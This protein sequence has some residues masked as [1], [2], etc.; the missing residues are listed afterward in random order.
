MQRLKLYSAAL[1]TAV[2]AISGTAVAASY[3]ISVTNLTNGMHFTPLILATHS[4]DARMFS[5][6]SEASAQLQAIAEGGDTSSMAALLESVGATVANGDGLIAPGGTA[7]FMIDDGAGSVL[8]LAG[9]LLP[10]ND[11]FVGLNSV[12]LPTGGAGAYAVYNAL[13]YDAGTEANDEIVG[14]GAPGE[15]GFPA[16][17]PVVATGTGVGGSGVPGHVEGFVH[18]HRN[19]IGDLDATG[20]ISDINQAVH[21]WLNPVARVTITKMGG[22]SAV[23]TVSGLN[24]VAYSSSALE[25]FWQAATSTSSYVTGYEIRRNG[26]VLE[27]REGLS[28]FDQNLEP[29]TDYTYEIRA[30]DADGNVGRPSA[31]AVRT[32]S[33]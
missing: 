20:G 33:Q 28:F 1:A 25:I 21:R 2:T 10:T 29:D 31:V 30:V 4:P 8:S 7:T 14:S 9:M 16:P 27:T 18:V 17:P 19:V 22:D 6:G 13:G 32:N 26:S 15:A 12:K 3:E 23:S 24:G 11:G 5:A